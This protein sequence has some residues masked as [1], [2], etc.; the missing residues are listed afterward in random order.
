VGR[1]WVKVATFNINNI[2]NINKRLRNLLGWLAKAEPDVVRLQERKAAPSAFLVASCRCSKT[3]HKNMSA[4]FIAD[5]ATFF[6]ASFL[7]VTSCLERLI[8]EDF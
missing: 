3:K 5:Q 2:N 7:T 4:C 8:D 6:H 1:G